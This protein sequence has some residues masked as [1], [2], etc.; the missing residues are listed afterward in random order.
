MK[1]LAMTT[2]T[3]KSFVEIDSIVDFMSCAR[4]IEHPTESL[5]SKEQHPMRLFV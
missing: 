3:K 5:S 4:R 1:D 2:G